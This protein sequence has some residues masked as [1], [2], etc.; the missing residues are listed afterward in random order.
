MEREGAMVEARHLPDRDGLFRLALYREHAWKIHERDGKTEIC[1]VFGD[2][3]A[4]TMVNERFGIREKKKG[5]K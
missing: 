5:K 1:T 2:L 3:C 4:V